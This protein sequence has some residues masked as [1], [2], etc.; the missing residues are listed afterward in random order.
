MPKYT[1]KFTVDWLR[2]V[3]PLPYRVTGSIISRKGT[4]TDYVET[5]ITS[6]ELMA[7]L[8]DVLGLSDDDS[9][10]AD[11]FDSHDVNSD[12]TVSDKGLWGYEKTKV[13]DGIRIMTMDDSYFST[14]VITRRVADMGVCFEFSGSAL[15][16]YELMMQ[17]RTGDNN[18]WLENI[19]RLFR[20]YPKAK[21]SRIDLTLD[22]L[23]KMSGVTPY[24]FYR[25]FRQ[26]Y[27]KATSHYWQYHDS[28]DD[29]FGSFGNTLTIGKRSSDFFLRVYDKQKERYWQHGDKWL[30]PNGF[31]IRWEEELKHDLA[32]KV[33]HEFLSRQVDDLYTFYEIFLDLLVSRIWVYPTKR[34]VKAGDY[35]Q[36]PYYRRDGKTGTR[37]M[38]SWYYQL[39]SPK[40][41]KKIKLSNPA[42]Y[43]TGI[44]KVKLYATGSLFE[45][46]AV[47]VL[48]GGDPL[49]LI[50]HWLK[51][52]KLKRNTPQYPA[53]IRQLKDLKYDPSF[54]DNEFTDD[55]EVFKVL[56]DTKFYYQPPVNK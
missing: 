1:Y 51:Q 31:D 11:D 36:A 2:F 52:G 13:L 17:E 9:R 20:R 7:D 34:Q 15:R 25:L 47:H 30:D 55:S 3:V 12:I 49:R 28:G 40:S 35:Q 22:I 48:N 24:A 6:K 50:A 37:N 4:P 19:A 33:V 41:R 56:K 32:D 44:D 45:K 23:T 18:T 5:D 27:V 42:G 14:D 39:V 16:R 29:R 54:I 53:L 26:N 38:A 8:I 43:V 10:L 21:V 46:L